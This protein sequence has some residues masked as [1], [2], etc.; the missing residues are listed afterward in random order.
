MLDYLI[1]IQR[2]I[3]TALSA[4]VAA[5]AATRNWAALLAVFPM[6]ILFGAVHAL[7][8]GHGKSILAAYLVGSRLAALR[9]AAVAVVQAFRHV[10]SAV[11]LALLSAPLITRSLGGVGR[12]PAL[13]FLS[14]GM[15]IV[16]GGWLIARAFFNQGHPHGEGL[17]VGF[18]AG[19][20]PCPLTLFAMFFALSRSVPE[21]GLMFAL[22]MMF[23][24]FATLAVVASTAVFMRDRVIILMERHGTSLRTWSRCLDGAAGL[25]LVLAS[26]N[27]L[28]R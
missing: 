9:A 17:A 2:A 25:L 3:Y 7:T 27:E 19:L 24:V 6:G 15:L 10:G 20:V 5:F 16:I 21:A 12:A 28:L 26:L 13:E 11:I 1:G 4:D 22:A 23:G 8:P 14:R 18:V